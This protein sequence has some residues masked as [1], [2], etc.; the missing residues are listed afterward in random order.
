MAEPGTVW[1]DRLA[2]LRLDMVERWRRGERRPA[3]SY[4]Q[5][6][7]DLAGDAEAVLELV[8]NEVVVRE[9]LGE[10]PLLDEYL[11]R[12]PAHAAALRRQ[13]ELHALLGEADRDS[14]ERPPAAPQLR[15]PSST[16]EVLTPTL[17]STRTTRRARP[18]TDGEELP[19][20]VGGYEILGELG[21]GGM[22][23]VY[24]A[25]QPG[26][27]R[28]VALKMIAGGAEG[29]ARF[30]LEAETVA[31]LQHPNIVQIYEI[32]SDNGRPFV[33]LEYVAGG[34]LAERLR[35]NV[36]EPAAA[37]GLLL[38]LARA[39]QHA[40]EQGVIHRDLKPANVLLTAGGTPRIADFGLAKCLDLEHGQTASGLIMGT[41]SYMPPEQAEGRHRVVGPAADVY[42]LGAVLYECLTGRPP[43]KGASVIDTIRA[44]VA[45]E[46]VSPSRLQSKT[47]R[48]LETI[49]LKCLQKEPAKRYAS[50]ADLADDL[51][52][53]LDGQPIR[54]RRTPPW[55]R[56]LKWT[57]RRPAAAAL[58]LVSILAVGGLLG[59]WAAF[60]ARLQDET[61]RADQLAR[62]RDQEAKEAKRLEGVAREE[63]ARA[64]KQSDLAENALVICV[65]AVGD[66]AHILGEGK[67]ADARASN[68]GGVLFELALT[69]ARS[70]N[71][72]R[73]N[74]GGL[75]NAQALRLAERYENGAAELLDAA[76]RIGYFRN[77]Q[78]AVQRRRLRTDPDLETLRRLPQFQ[79]LLERMGSS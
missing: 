55:E 60:T 19:E 32:G 78:N 22:G 61:R 41:P 37:A 35:G 73:A 69:Y 26:L 56:L 18:G 24:Q 8:Y 25:R 53:S 48:D 62:Q 28:L 20:R 5:A 43:F 59:V 67:M 40:H 66:F 38:T 79:Q 31:R 76:D 12:F 57:R 47:P 46:P 3:E 1:R 49:C 77:P 45:E 36:L 63:A 16:T 15:T 29:Q 42:A 7:A 21:R 64:K 39:V 4:L 65:N 70:A 14:R 74:W 44:V 30:Q 27:G 33:A 2:A 11:H 34:S 71:K 50:A 54:A 23:V 58:V 75:E 17:P 72:L 10:R 52:R 6:E 68:P 51:Q 9:E 13:L